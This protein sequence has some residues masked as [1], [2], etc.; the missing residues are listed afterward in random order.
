MRKILFFAS[1]LSFAATLRSII[2]SGIHNNNSAFIG[3]IAAFLLVYGIFYHKLVKIKWLTVAIFTVIV[4]VFG[5]STFLGVYGRRSSAGYNED[6]AIVLGAGTRN[7]Y[8]RTTLGMRLDKAVEYHR[9]NPNA[10]IVVSGG[11]G[12]RETLTEAEIMAQYLI[13]NG[14]PAELIILEKEAYSTYSN[15]RYSK[16]LIDEHFNFIP[17]AVIITSD[18]HMF[19]SIRFSQMAGITATVYP[20]GTPW[21]S[22]PFAYVREVAAVIKMWLIGR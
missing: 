1:F 3:G 19:R 2:I 12:H 11:Q 9:R 7:G 13:D 21:Y 5:F 20:S 15:M 4:S 22:M 16:V 17:N 8:V 10:L 6:V 14:V 18:F